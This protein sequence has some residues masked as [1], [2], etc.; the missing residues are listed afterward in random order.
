M[1]QLHWFASAYD[2]DDW[3]YRLATSCRWS[4]S[5]SWRWLCMF[6][7]IDHGDTSTTAVMVAGYVV[8]RVALYC[9]GRA[10]PARPGT[11]AGRP[12][13]RRPPSP[14]RRSAGSP[15]SSC[16]LCGRLRPRARADRA[17][18][19][20]P[21]ACRKPGRHAVARRA[22]RG[23]LRPARDHRLGEGVVGTVASIAPV[24]RAHGWTFDAAFVAVR[25]L[26]LTFAIWWTYSWISGRPPPRPPRA[27][28]P[29]L[30]LLHIVLF[31][32]YRGHRC[33]PAH[34]R[35]T[36]SS[37]HSKLGSVVDGV[38]PVAVPVGAFIPGRLCAVRA[39]A[40]GQLTRSMCCFWCSTRGRAWRGGLAG[41]GGHFNRQLPV[42][43]SR[44]R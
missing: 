28:I 42:G 3:I 9:S 15:P 43:S 29:V 4:A 2:T 24:G 27:V 18:A 26:G 8:M 37:T 5:S 13:L 25:G 34:Q 17:R 11:A 38:R 14:S 41:R 1:D 20:R 12:H 22:H 40:C 23:T 7:S 35:R 16:T 32:S 21:L 39:D 10:L 19:A 44:W 33:G 6:A 30:L 31:G 36:T